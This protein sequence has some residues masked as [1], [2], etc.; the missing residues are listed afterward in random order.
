VKALPTV[1]ANLVYTAGFNLDLNVVTGP[2]EPGTRTRNGI[3][4]V[5]HHQGTD[6]RLDWLGRSV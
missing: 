2:E 4:S 1:L 6:L 5:L 3:W